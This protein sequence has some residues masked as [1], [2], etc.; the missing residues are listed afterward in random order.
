MTAGGELRV[1]NDRGRIRPSCRVL[2][3]CGHLPEHLPLV[4]NGHASRPLAR[5]GQLFPRGKQGTSA[6]RW[7]RQSFFNYFTIQ[8]AHGT[9]ST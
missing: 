5:G 1:T 2:V 6:S 4:K 9:L 8:A 7:A 3:C